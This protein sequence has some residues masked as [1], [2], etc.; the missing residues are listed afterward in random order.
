VPDW[1]ANIIEEFRTNEGRLGG[2]FE[3]RT[4]LLLHHVGARTGTERVN[5]LAYQDLGDGSIAVFASKGGSDT[6]PDWFYNLVANPKAS[7]EVGTESWDVVARVAED[8]E[9]ERIWETQ[10]RLMPGFATY[11]ERTTR[12]IPVIVLDRA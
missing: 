11:E 10:K 9:R 8:D 5:P 4:M 12:E 1:N 6:N 2:P 7:V 3:G